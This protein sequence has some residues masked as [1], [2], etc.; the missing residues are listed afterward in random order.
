M[1]VRASRYREAYARWQG[2]PE[3]FWADAAKETRLRRRPGES[4]EFQRLSTGQQSGRDECV[5]RELRAIEG[6]DVAVCTP[7]RGSENIFAPC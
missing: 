5:N 6:I 1:D 3:G 4:A 2:D 7:D